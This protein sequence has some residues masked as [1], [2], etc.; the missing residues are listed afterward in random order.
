ME[1]KY[2]E[3][4]NDRYCQIHSQNLMWFHEEPSQIVSDVLKRYNRSRSCKILEIGCGEGRDAIPL[5]Q[6]GHNLLATDVSCEAISFCM[7][8]CPDFA[9]CF[10]MLDCIAGELATKFDYIFSVAVIHMLVQDFD[11]NAFYR[12]I[13]NHLNHEGIALICSMGDGN[14]EGKTDIR[15]AFELQDRIHEQTGKKV[16]IASTSCRM[17]TTETF[18]EELTRNGFLILE[19]GLTSV[20]PDFPTMMYAV[21]K[22]T[23]EQENGI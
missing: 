18:R 13:H 6:S 2:Y 19:E 8:K 9:D 23:D 21:I 11:R 5:L 14:V 15:N 4:Y 17:V 7:K 20:E 10:Q 22:R 16:R 3:A 1:R 12:F